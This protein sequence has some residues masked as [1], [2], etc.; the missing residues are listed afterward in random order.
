MNVYICHKHHYYD[1]EPC[2][3]CQKEDLKQDKIK[4]KKCRYNTCRQ[5]NRESKSN[6]DRYEK[7]R[8]YQC[9]TIR[10]DS[11][12]KRIEARDKLIYLLDE[13]IHG[14][15]NTLGMK[16]CLANP[17]KGCWDDELEREA[18]LKREIKKADII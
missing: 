14:D 2:P 11:L 8:M 10:I 5:Y 6:C 4:M 15:K 1:D 3:L 16:C 17:Y 18:I 7:D 13:M 9:P 12:Q